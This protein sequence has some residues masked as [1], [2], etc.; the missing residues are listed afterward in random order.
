MVD[1]NDKLF[2]VTLGTKLRQIRERQG[3]SIEELSARMA[4]S[5]DII[6]MIEEGEY[7]NMSV[8][9]IGDYV[10]F[11]GFEDFDIVTES[12]LVMQ[13]YDLS[14]L[15]EEFLYL[16]MGNHD[17]ALALS[18]VVCRV[19]RT[20]RDGLTSLEELELLGRVCAG[21]KESLDSCEFTPDSVPKVGYEDVLE[22]EEDD[23]VSFG[24]VLLE[25]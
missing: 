11:C 5:G 13:V 3:L 12:K 8:G 23:S 21:L 1:F 7:G 9:L 24:E 6:S 18:D 10:A 25:E 2:C 17:K 16:G 4:L 20:G 22:N 15:L 14:C 19:V